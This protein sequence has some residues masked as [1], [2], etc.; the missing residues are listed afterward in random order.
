MMTDASKALSYDAVFRPFGELQSLPVNAAT[1]NLRFPGQYQLTETGLAH[2]WHRQYDASIGRYL[3]PDPLGFVDGPS[4]YAYA[5]SSPGMEVDDFGGNSRRGGAGNFTPMQQTYATI[6][7]QLGNQIRQY[8]PNYQEITSRNF[9]P[10]LEQ[11]R[12]LTEEL[13]RYESGGVGP[14]L[15]GRAG[16]LAVRNQ[17]RIGDPARFDVNGNRRIADGRT[18]HSIISEIK[19]CGY[20]C[21]TQQLRDY[22]DY[23][24]STGRTFDLY[25]THPNPT[26]SRSLQQL[27]DNGQIRLNP[28]FTP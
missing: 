19:N 11:I 13:R 22:L 21:M 10:G 7:Q 16:E 1:I 20:V 18:D 26:N 5:R 2:N 25:N 12:Q 23:P 6:Y 8:N 14:N 3:Q 28:E 24:R 4:V 9:N 17:C 27:I 15:S